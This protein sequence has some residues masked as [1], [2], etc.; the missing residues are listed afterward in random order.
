[1]SKAE[2]WLKW[3]LRVIGASA[4]LAVAAVVMPHS[5]L[6]F[7]V[8]RVKPGTPVRLLVP[9][10]ARLVSAYYVLLG[11]LMMFL[12]CDVRRYEHVIRLVAIWCILAGIVLL[13]YYTLETRGS[14]RGWFFWFI[15]G[16]AVFGI[17]FGSCLLLLQRKID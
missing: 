6:V 16:D 9:Y 14:E 5:W 17:A 13:S 3:L 15:C 11:L 12:A 8:E 7:C 2:L 10:L 4:S 1:M